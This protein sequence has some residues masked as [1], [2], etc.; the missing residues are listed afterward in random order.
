ML[1]E[2]GYL[3]DS[4]VYTLL[5]PA[6]FRS[7]QHTLDFIE[8]VVRY[9]KADGTL[10][11]HIK[12]ARGITREVQGTD[13]YVR[14]GCDPQHGLPLE[15]GAL[16][17]DLGVY[18]LRLQTSRAGIVLPE[19]D[20]LSP[21]ATAQ[22]SLDGITHQLFRGDFFSRRSFLDLEYQLVGKLYGIGGHVTILL[23]CGKSSTLL[24]CP[25]VDPKEKKSVKLTDAGVKLLEFTKGVMR[26]KDGFYL[27]LTKLNDGFDITVA[28]TNYA[29]LTYAE[30]L[31][32]SYRK[33]NDKGSLNPGK[34]FWQQDRVWE[35]LEDAVLNG[36]ADVG[37][38]SYPP[39]R[40]KEFPK[41]LTQ[42][43]WVAEEYVFVVPAKIA[44]TVKRDRL[45]ISD[46]AGV[47]TDLPRVALS[48]GTQIRQDSAHRAIPEATAR[49]FPIS[50]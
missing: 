47:M 38:Y 18:I 45:S 11:G 46:L 39:S 25:L 50:G 28:T 21:L 9:H 3:A 20:G 14:V 33:I 27:E 7:A 30:E 1:R 6:A 40:R 44:A 43:D 29:W 8:D 41:D 12:D 36:Q 17:R 42:I 10:F 35:E 24:E 32:G 5:R 49:S 22:A 31:E 13:N 37:I 15:F 2:S 4:I 34:G 26:L 23:L 48:P 19:F 16:G